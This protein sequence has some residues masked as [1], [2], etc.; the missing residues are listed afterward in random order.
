[1]ARDTLSGGI[2]RN[3][4]QEAPR[5]G[6]ALQSS[7]QVVS[8]VGVDA[9]IVTLTLFT[10]MRFVR[11]ISLCFTTDYAIHNYQLVKNRYTITTSPQVLNTCLYSIPHFN[12]KDDI[13]SVLIPNA[14][15]KIPNPEPGL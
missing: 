10:S 11:N 4:T 9:F 6:S 5:G 3:K 8:V 13:S 2:W 1:M 7:M 14:D 12:A 15:T